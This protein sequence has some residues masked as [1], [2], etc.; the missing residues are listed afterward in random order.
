[1]TRLLYRLLFSF[2]LLAVL[3]AVERRFGLGGLILMVAFVP[4]GILFFRTV[5]W[6][7]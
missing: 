7:L 4:V 5:L 2:L 3:R 1:M 6:V